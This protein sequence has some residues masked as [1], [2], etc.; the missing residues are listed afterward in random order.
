M[1]IAMKLEHVAPQVLFHRIYCFVHVHHVV[2]AIVQRFLKQTAGRGSG[3]H[4]DTHMH[5]MTWMCSYTHVQ[6]TSQDLVL[7]RLG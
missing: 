4:T 6:Q 3:L 1:A 7:Y 2:P 5:A